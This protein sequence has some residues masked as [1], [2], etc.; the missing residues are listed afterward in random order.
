MKIPNWYELLVL[1][2]AVW[3]TFQLLAFDE[4]AQP[5]RGRLLRMGNWREEGDPVPENYRV[6]WAK[7]ITC[8]Y[9]AGTWTALAWWGAWQLSQHWT[10]VVASLA[11]L[12]TLPIAGHKVLSREQDR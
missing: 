8:P 3:R 4:I 2:L 9:C 11:A 7:F 1:G 6:E 12:A 10:M 5:L